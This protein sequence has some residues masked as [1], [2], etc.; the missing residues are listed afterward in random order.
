[1]LFPFLGGRAFF[2]DCCSAIHLRWEGKE[3]QKENTL[4]P[5]EL[6]IVEL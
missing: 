2:Y 3:F 4:V 1:M 6:E 5:G